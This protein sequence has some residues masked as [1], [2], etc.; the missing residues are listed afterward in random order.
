MRN[1]TRDEGRS[2]EAASQVP[3]LMHSRPR[4]LPSSTKHWTGR[5]IRPVAKELR[6][7]AVTADNH[8]PADSRIDFFSSLLAL[9]L[10]A[11]PVP[12]ETDHSD[13]LPS[14]PPGMRARIENKIAER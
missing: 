14:H 11:R 6:A 12:V 9:H 3:M 5:G 8:T 2:F 7:A 10:A 13:R 4:C 1:C